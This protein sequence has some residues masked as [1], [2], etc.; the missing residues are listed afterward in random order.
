MQ[1]KNVQ[2]KMPIVLC[3]YFVH[4]MLNLLILDFKK[5]TVYAHTRLN[6]MTYDLIHFK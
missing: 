6:Y 3:P 5:M 1:E 2:I 4:C